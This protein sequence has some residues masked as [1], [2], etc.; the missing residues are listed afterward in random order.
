MAPQAEQARGGMAATRSSVAR[1]AGR[2][3]GRFEQHRRYAV[4][5]QQ[6][7]GFHAGSSSHPAVDV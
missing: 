6:L 4:P 7:R 2:R 3:G 1:R 5:G